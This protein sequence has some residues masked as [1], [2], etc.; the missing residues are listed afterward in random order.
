MLTVG[1]GIAVLESPA[2][3][4]KLPGMIAP[5]NA[6]NVLT[7]P[8]STPTAAQWTQLFALQAAILDS[9]AKAPARVRA[10]P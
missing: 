6:S 8:S 4:R 2:S 5:E 9:L 7:S 1:F 3:L 10:I